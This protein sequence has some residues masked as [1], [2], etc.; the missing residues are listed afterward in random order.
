M[1]SSKT[2]IIE[3]PE[4]NLISIEKDSGDEYEYF[5]WDTGN[6]YDSYEGYE[7]DDNFNYAN[8]YEDEN[9]YYSNDDYYE[10]DY[11]WDAYYEKISKG[12]ANLVVTKKSFNPA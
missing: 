7:Y 5:S 12:K 8:Y 4:F 2:E 11:D 9:D 6:V 10:D 3:F 1:L